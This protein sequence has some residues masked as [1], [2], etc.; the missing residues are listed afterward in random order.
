MSSSKT[1]SLPGS[2]P[3]PPE[4]AERLRTDSFS[5]FS[6]YIQ[7]QHEL[8]LEEPIENPAEEQW[9]IDLSEKLKQHAFFRNLL[10]IL[11]KRKGVVPLPEIIQELDRVVPE[12]QGGGLEYRQTCLEAPV[13]FPAPGQTG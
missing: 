3:S 1:P 9:K 12:F 5:D 6:S 10:M 7:T 4:E 13:L 8:W 2:R 11:E